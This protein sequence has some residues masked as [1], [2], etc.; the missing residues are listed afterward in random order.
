MP[1][2]VNVGAP[3]GFH[4]LQALILE[5]ADDL[6]R[7]VPGAFHGEVPGPAWPDRDYHSPWIDLWG[8]RHQERIDE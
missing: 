6:L 3:L 5:L 2:W 8:P 4:L 1:L 7:R